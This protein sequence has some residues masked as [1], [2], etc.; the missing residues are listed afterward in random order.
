VK[1]SN[2]FPGLRPFKPEESTLFF[3]RDEQIGE[4]LDRLMRN[5][6]L[7]VLGLSGCGK[8]SLVIAGMVPTLQMGLAGDPRQQW[9]I[10]IMRPGDSPLRELERCL[11]FEGAPLARRTY[12]LREAVKANLPPAQNLLLVVDQFEEI[13]S[14]RDRMPGGSNESDLFISYLLS[15]AQ[16]ADARIYIILTMRSDYLGECATFHGLPEALNDAQYLVPRMTRSQLQEA[17]EN[18]LKTILG[19]DGE[20]VHFH[21]GLVQKLLNDCDDE[22]DNL[23]L[24]QHLLRRLVEQWQSEGA[25]GQITPAMALEVGELAGALNNDA[26]KVFQALSSEQQRIAE[27]V[28]RRITESRRHAD[29]AKDDRPVRRPQTVAHLRELAQ[30]PEAGLRDVLQRFEQRGLLVVRRTDEFDKVD[31]PHECLGLKWKRLKDWIETEAQ[32]AKTLRF[33]AD[34]VGHSHLTGSALTEA[35]AWHEANRL[36]GLWGQRYLSREYLT[37]VD[38]WITESKRRVDAL[39]EEKARSARRLRSYLITA[40]VLAVV[41]IATSVWAW[42]EKGNADALAR[43]AA[44]QSKQAQAKEAA[45][46]KAFID[47]NIVSDPITKLQ[48]TKTD[49]FE[50]IGWQKADNYCQTLKLAGLSGWKLATIDDLKHL[51]DRSV[52]GTRRIRSPFRLTTPNVWSSMEID[53]ESAMLFSFNTGEANARPK[54]NVFPYRALCV[55]PTGE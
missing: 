30:V 16:D 36:K 49:N 33:L 26:E 44:E 8:S 20:A 53:S 9:R 55:R 23:P 25:M 52:R 43:L 37:Q 41:A 50:D 19:V 54:S 17:I 35:I 1:P 29:S 42:R 45:A 34:S 48:W 11:G 32:D 38:D 51:F 39:A 46:T 7:A 18:P 27:V 47:D 28:L 15:A 31:L 24:L 3:G 21:M 40:V 14:F 13:F 5:K 6:L 4:A 10:E 22:P 2:P 12:A